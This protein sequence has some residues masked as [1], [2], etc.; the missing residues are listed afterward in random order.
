MDTTTTTADLQACFAHAA[1]ISAKR[2]SAIGKPLTEDEK[3]I[4][5][6]AFAKGADHARAQEAHALALLDRIVNVADL[7]LTT[8]NKSMP[9][10]M[11]PPP[12]WLSDARELLVSTRGGAA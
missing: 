4:A 10:D 1:E 11:T 3:I 9:I 6:C 5:A 2:D 7:L 12:S 8:G